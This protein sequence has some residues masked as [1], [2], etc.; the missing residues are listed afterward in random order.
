[1]VTMTRDQVKTCPRCGKPLIFNHGENPYCMVHGSPRETIISDPKKTPVK[2]SAASTEPP[3][4]PA[5]GS[6]PADHPEGRGPSP[7][8]GVAARSA[9]ENSKL[10]PGPGDPQGQTAKSGDI[11]P[12]PKSKDHFAMHRYYETNKTAIIR[13]INDLGNDAASIRWG[14]SL[15]QISHLKRNWNLIPHSHKPSKQQPQNKISCVPRPNII[16]PPLPDFNPAWSIEI[17]EAWLDIY[18][19]LVKRGG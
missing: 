9:A 1:M 12:K 18:I 5:A 8:P 13:D 2:K 14:I 3:A 10:P 4:D 19:L 16:L 15:S 11:P 6:S 7:D 17:Q